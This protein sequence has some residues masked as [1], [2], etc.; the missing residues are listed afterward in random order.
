MAKKTLKDY[1]LGIK[2][3]H[4]YTVRIANRVLEDH[5]IT[6][7]ENNL[8]AQELIEM[9]APEKTIFQSHP[10]GFTQPTKSEVLI[11]N[12][13]LGMPQ[14]CFWLAREIAQIL[15]ISEIYVVVNGSD[16]PLPELHIEK[17]P[18]YVPKVSTD[19]AYPE[20]KMLPPHK[21]LAGTEYVD[22]MLKTLEKARKK[23]PASVIWPAS[24]KLK[25]QK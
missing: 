12:V 4:T 11:F 7:I 24:D 6:R 3:E 16:N 14:S 21:D 9:T 25:P 2:K 17:D 8:K 19:P 22:N 1:L 23:D 13:K 20:D 15:K 5:D 18:N 10:L